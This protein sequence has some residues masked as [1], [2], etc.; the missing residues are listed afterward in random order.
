MRRKVELHV[1]RRLRRNPYKKRTGF[2]E[3]LGK[4]VVTGLAVTG[5]V[6]LIKAF[7]KKKGD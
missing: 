3:F 1:T 6:T 7:D 4:A 5:T 2:F